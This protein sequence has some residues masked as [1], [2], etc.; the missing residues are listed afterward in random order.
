MPAAHP[1]CR[2][3]PPAACPPPDDPFPR[4]P[5]S[6]AESCAGRSSLRSRGTTL[7]SAADFC[8][9]SAAA[10]A[11]EY[12][13]SRVI[14]RADPEIAFR[15]RQQIVLRERF[16]AF[17]FP[18]HGRFGL[19]KRVEQ[20][21]VFEATECQRHVFLKKAD[22]ARQLLERDLGINARRVLQVGTCGFKHFRHPALARRRQLQT[23]APRSEIPAH[24]Y[25]HGVGGSA[26]I[27]IRI[28]L[29]AADRFDIEQ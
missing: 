15:A 4:H 7:D 28:C 10:G 16:A 14:L 25:E 1:T 17:E 8:G 11:A 9:R 26:R 6:V 21:T 19:M 5:E 20:R 12:R 18:N 29:P 13:P 23:F 22:D 27:A 2:E 3:K 24:D